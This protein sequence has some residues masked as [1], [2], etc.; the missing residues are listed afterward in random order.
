MTDPTAQNLV[1]A[2]AAAEELLSQKWGTAIRLT[3]GEQ[4]GL[5]NRSHV[6]RLRVAQRRADI[7]ET[8][9]LKQAALRQESDVYDPQ[10]ADGPASRHFNEW[11]GLQFLS[12]VCSD[13]LPAPSF[14]GGDREIGFVIIE[15]FGD[16]TRLDHLLLG[17]DAAAAER[18]V[19]ALF[20]TIGRMHA[21]TVGQASR[22]LEIRTALGPAPSWVTNIGEISEWDRQR[23]EYA[24]ERFGIEAHPAFFDELD[25]VWNRVRT[26]GP[27]TA[28]MHCDAC[29]DNC[30]WVGNELRLLDF[31]G[32][33]YGHLLN[34]AV[35]IHLP[36]PSCWC[37]NRLPE[38]EQEEAEAAYRAELIKGCPQA[39]DDGLFYSA[40]VSVGIHRVFDIFFRHGVNAGR[41]SNLDREWGIST[42]GQRCLMWFGQVAW[43][44]GRFGYFPGIGAT[45]QRATAR[46][47]SHQPKIDEMPYYP[48]FR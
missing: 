28:Y 39:A 2:I 43:L 26:P 9:I 36:F 20:Q 40:L 13:P 6:H 35:Y 4:T 15:D 25:A 22:Y 21:Q 5:S 17:Q 47:R 42:I 24:L 14:F 1:E 41:L 10:A 38:A 31:E 19:I 7:P 8:V 45:A 46:F 23:M 48:A 29:P 27:F 3:P 30:H 34:D 12:E 16:G 37:S 44:A 32:G 33:H 18:G 11:A